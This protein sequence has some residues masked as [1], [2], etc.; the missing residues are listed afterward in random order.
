MKEIAMGFLH[1]G[2]GIRFT[3]YLKTFFKEAEKYRGTRW[4]N[5][6]IFIFKV[7]VIVNTHL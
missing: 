3:S 4:G 1:R 7:K 2:R 5:A 6:F